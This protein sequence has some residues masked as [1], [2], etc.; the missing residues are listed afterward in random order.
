MAAE[1]MEALCFGLD[2]ANCDNK[3]THDGTKNLSEGSSRGEK[4][5][6]AWSKTYVRRKRSS[7]V[8]DCHLQ[9]KT[10]TFTPIACQTRQRS[11]TNPLGAGI[12]S[13]NSGKASTLNSKQSGE[14]EPA[15]A[16]VQ[17]SQKLSDTVAAIGIGEFRRTRRKLSGQLNGSSNLHGLVNQI[18]EQEN[19]RQSREES[20]RPKTNALKRKNRA[21]KYDGPVLS[22]VDKGVLGCAA[23]ECSSDDGNVYPK[24]MVG[25]LASKLSDR[26]SDADTISAGGNTK[27]KV[28]PVDKCKSSGSVSGTPISCITPVSAA[29]PICEGD[30]KQSSRKNLSRSFL[31]REIS[32]LFSNSSE[33]T[34]TIRDSRRRRREMAN[35][36]VLFSH[37]LNGDIIK[38]QKKVLFCGIFHSFLSRFKLMRVHWRLCTY[39]RSLP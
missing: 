12:A 22:A 8:K 32:S 29:L 23:F 27:L 21:S 10:G 15:T 7:S 19:R 1:A 4:G 2:V 33:G 25:A 28:L 38:H 24:D 3:D 20:N 39:F 18:V 26:Q 36:R 9:G 11:L 31:V 17:S 16:Q 13:Y 37:H 6:R 14:L 34:S 30:L 5:N 35:V